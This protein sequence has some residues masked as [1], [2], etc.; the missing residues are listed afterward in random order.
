MGRVTLTRRHP[1]S[2]RSPAPLHAPATYIHRSPDHGKEEAALY[3]FSY[4]LTCCCSAQNMSRESLSE[5][6][7]EDWGTCV[8][9]F[10][11]VGVARFPL[12]KPYSGRQC[13]R[14]CILHIPM[15]STHDMPQQHS[16]PCHHATT[17]LIRRLHKAPSHRASN[18]QCYWTVGQVQDFFTGDFQN[19]MLKLTIDLASHEDLA[20]NEDL[21]QGFRAL[22]HG[23]PESIRS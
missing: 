20:V 10:H 11:Q 8:E 2:L 22:L 14:S 18:H 16:C 6:L 1:D 21:V 23:L 5:H 15:A 12:A 13:M 9:S 19:C 17:S 3:R 4:Q 7:E